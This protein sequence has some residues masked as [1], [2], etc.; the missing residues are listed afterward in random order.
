MI[1]ILQF[2]ILF[3]FAICITKSII[4][5]INDNIGK[6]CF[7]MISG[8]VIDV[9]IMAITQIIASVNSKKFADYVQ[10]GPKNNPKI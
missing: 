2:A 9:I 8:V 1:K 5:Y 6:A 4:F 7:W 10:Y 3:S